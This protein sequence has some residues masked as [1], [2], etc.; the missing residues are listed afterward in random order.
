[1]VRQKVASIL[2]EWFSIQKYIAEEDGEGGGEERHL[3]PRQKHK[4]GKKVKC[5]PLFLVAEGKNQMN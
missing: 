2:E 1:M 3:L 5:E 4:G